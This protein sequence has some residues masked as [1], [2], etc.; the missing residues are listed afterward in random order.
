M[1][2]KINSNEINKI[3][4][5]IKLEIK[6]IDLNDFFLKECF[7]KEQVSLLL[8]QLVASITN[9]IKNNELPNKNLFYVL[10]QEHEGKEFWDVIE[11]AVE[12]EMKPYRDLA[13]FRGKNES[14]RIFLLQVLI[15]NTIVFSEEKE[16]ISDMLEE[17]IENITPINKMLNTC[18]NMIFQDAMTKRAFEAN[19]KRMFGL[20]DADIQFIW[21]EFNKERNRIQFNVIQSQ[22]NVLQ[23]Q[24]QETQE[25]NF[26]IQELLEKSGK[27]DEA[28][29]G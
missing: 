28:V 22:F 24:L 14:E 9:I 18:V 3:I 13:K 2:N 1:I 7:E 12:D 10:N 16:I 23:D 4:K 25:V 6:P 5:S 19:V 11:A 27:S 21:S 20:K 15:T 17:K 26:Q 8:N 29:E